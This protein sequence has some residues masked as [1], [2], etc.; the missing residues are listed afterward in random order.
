[1]FEI[2]FGEVALI[3]C[4][5]MVPFVKKVWGWLRTLLLQ[6]DSNPHTAGDRKSARTSSL[7]SKQTVFENITCS[8]A[9]WHLTLLTNLQLLNKQLKLQHETVWAGSTASPRSSRVGWNN[10][11]GVEVVPKLH[12]RVR[13][14]GSQVSFKGDRQRVYSSSSWRGRRP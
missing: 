10:W 3:C 4:S 1:M 12:P 11:S 14:G 13:A 9:L 6:V 5:R 8:T 7:R 2:H